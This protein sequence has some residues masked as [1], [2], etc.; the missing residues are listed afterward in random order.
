MSVITL[1]RYELEQI[2]SET[3]IRSAQLASQKTIE[4]LGVAPPFLS[5]REAGRQYGARRVNRWI[6][7]GLVKPVHDG[8]TS[9]K[10]VIVSEL[11]NAAIGENAFRFYTPKK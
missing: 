2:V 6:K 10:R 11:L 9:P 4:Q 7:Q 1:E 8:G 5:L 3:A